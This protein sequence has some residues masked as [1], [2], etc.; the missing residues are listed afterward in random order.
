M[1]GKETTTSQMETTVQ[2]TTRN[3]MRQER[4]NSLLTRRNLNINVKKKKYYTY[5]IMYEIHHSWAQESLLGFL[6]PCFSSVRRTTHTH[7]TITVAITK[8]LMVKSRGEGLV[9]LSFPSHHH[10]KG[11]TKDQRW[12]EYGNTVPAVKFYHKQHAT[13]ILTLNQSESLRNIHKSSC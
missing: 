3:L 5:T 1:Q 13:L 6:F 9:M 2:H 7:F 4:I 10:L 8:C 12:I 11:I